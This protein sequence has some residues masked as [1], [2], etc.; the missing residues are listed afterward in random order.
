MER[1][2]NILDYLYIEY[3]NSNQLSYSRVMKLLFLI[4]WKYAITKFQKLTD[5]EWVLSPYGP[6]YKTLSSIFTE[7][8]NFDV[9]IRF[10]EKNKEQLL[11]K[12]FNNKKVIGITDDSR[13]V[14]LFVVNHCKDFSWT[15]LN[16]LVNSTYAV[17]NAKEGQIID[18]LTL[19]KKYRN[20]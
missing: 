4:E 2:I 16:N 20:G 1:V 15:E 14:V 11:I 10:D 7:S 19:A 17:I 9:S 12:F 8:S 6:F 13:D 18:I 5:I 3:P